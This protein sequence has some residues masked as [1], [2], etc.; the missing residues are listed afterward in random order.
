M[1]EEE[2][3]ISFFAREKKERQVQ[4]LKYIA[5][6][7]NAELNKVIG[8]FSFQWGLRSSTVKK[9][10]E[11]LENAGLIEISEDA[12]YSVVITENG[13]EALKEEMEEGAN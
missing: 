12:P 4:L 9:Y 6:F 13:L 11:E 3:V 8:K 7:K 2:H 5:E 10:L 1:S